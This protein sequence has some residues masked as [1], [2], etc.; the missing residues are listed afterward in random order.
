MNTP[1]SGISYLIAGFGLITKSGL[2]RFVII[3]LIINIFF[4]VGLFFLL[5]HYVG[6]FNHWF[7]SLLP[8]WLRWLEIILWI[9]FFASFMLVLFYTFIAIANIISAPFNSILAEKVELYLTGKIPESRSIIENVKD[10]PR[11]IGRQLAILIYYL[12]R[13]IVLFI[14]F[15]IPIVQAI[16]PILWFLFN[17]WYLVLTFVDYPTDNHRIPIRDVRSWLK[18]RSWTSLSFGSGVLLMSM[19]PVINFFI[20]PAAVAGAT[21]FWIEE[22]RK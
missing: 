1:F 10:V 4:F 19:I 9:C 15:F 2:R 18:Q 17:A 11:I 3:P 14:L 6:E 21:K 5:R 13:V 7:E 22:N 12:P 8:S 16:A 20:I